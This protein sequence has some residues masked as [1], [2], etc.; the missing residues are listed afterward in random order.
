MAIE[1]LFKIRSPAIGMGT[2]HISN[3][4]KLKQIEQADK[5]QEISKKL[6]VLTIFAAGLFAILSGISSAYF[7]KFF[8]KYPDLLNIGGVA[9]IIALVIIFIGFFIVKWK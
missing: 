5:H 2:G 3:E 7:T 8:D 6:V 1:D 9:I 4:I